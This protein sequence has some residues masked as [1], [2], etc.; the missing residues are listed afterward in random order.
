VPARVVQ[1]GNSLK[2]T[3]QGHPLIGRLDE[4]K[5]VFV[6]GAV[7]VQDDQF[8]RIHVRC[9]LV[10]S[11]G[12]AGAPVSGRQ[13]RQI[14]HA[15]HRQVQGFEQTQPVQAQLDRICID[16]DAFEEGIDRHA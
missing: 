4:L 2:R 12:C 10:S 5:T 14:C 3:G 7:A 1:A 6:D 15:V 8:E 9:Q 16:H 11:A 13:T